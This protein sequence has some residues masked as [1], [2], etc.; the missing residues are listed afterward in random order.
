MNVGKIDSEAGTA[1]AWTHAWRPLTMLMMGCS[2]ALLGC[3][4]GSQSDSGLLTEVTF[5]SAEGQPLTLSPAFSP[6][7]HDYTL[8]CAQGTNGLT[9]TAAVGSAGTVS[10]VSPTAAAVVRGQ[11]I[12]VALDA[13]QAAVLQTRTLDGQRTQYWFRCLPP[14]FPA[15]V[16]ALHREAG[17][18]T[19]GWYLMGN[20]V[21]APGES[22]F[23][24]ILDGNGT[25]VWYSRSPGG[26]VN[27][28]MLAANTVTYFE[29]NVG[30][31]RVRHLDSGQASWVKAAGLPTDVHELQQLPSGN[32]LLLSYP[33]LSG[34]DLTG[35]QSYGSDS[36][37]LDCVIQEVDP[38]GALQ[39][40]WR[41]SD[42]IDPVQESTYPK[43]L[44][45][46][47]QSLIDVY[48]CNSI[49][50]DRNG[51][52]MVSARHLDSV[53]FISKQTGKIVWKLGGA[54][55][56]KDGAQLITMLDAPSATFFRQHDAR[57]L[58]DGG[59]SLFD[60]QTAMS[61]VARGV[62]Y[63]IDFAAAT[64]QLT[65]QY[66]GPTSSLAMGS[67]RHYDDGSRVVCWGAPSTGQLAV[68]EF[69]AAGANLLDISFGKLEYSYRGLKVPVSSFDLNVLRQAVGQP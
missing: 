22:G 52:L 9:L 47:G 23:A 8:R 11:P 50:A 62:E 24:M 6:D 53:F 64:A 48:H 65:M 55:Y 35:L 59:I 51:D 33:P 69:N 54:R 7:I 14:D 26:A 40:Q 27:I 5:A 43:T 49:A 63:R 68:S 29:A 30:Q 38:S 61:A 45:E 2:L 1:I 57:F 17:Q 34:I 46:N 66:A 12:A 56:S 44:T 41:A 4:P 58:A 19:P 18:P 15:L 60:D 21:V 67:F 37:I 20:S 36:A 42:H 32:Y 28:E 10:L 16:V 25:P 3:D 31:Y 39:W 13:D